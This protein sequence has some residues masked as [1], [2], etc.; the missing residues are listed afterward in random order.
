MSMKAERKTAESKGNLM[1]I[2]RIDRAR[3]LPKK[4]KKKMPCG[5]VSRRKKIFLAE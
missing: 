4:R 5:D 3:L 2:G 1:N